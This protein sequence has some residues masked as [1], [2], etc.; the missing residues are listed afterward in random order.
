M[1]VSCLVC[2]CEKK[3]DCP[4]LAPMRV[5]NMTAVS[6]IIIEHPNQVLCPNCGTLVVPAVLQA[7]VAVGMAP[8]PTMDQK[9]VILSP[10]GQLVQ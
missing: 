10:N 1:Q 7:E 8:V 5:V 6:V 3:I 4:P 2:E 9:P